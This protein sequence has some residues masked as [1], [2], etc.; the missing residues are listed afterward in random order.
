MGDQNFSQWKYA[1]LFLGVKMIELIQQRLAELEKS[2]HEAIMSYNRVLGM[3]DEAKFHL[4]QHMIQKT[5]KL[6]AEAGEIAEAIADV[7]NA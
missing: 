3:I 7:A 2:K 1:P 4:E 6:A 5:E